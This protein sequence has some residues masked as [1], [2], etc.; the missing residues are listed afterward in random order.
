MS[1]IEDVARSW[2][3]A[4]PWQR[5]FKHTLDVAQDYAAATMVAVGAVALSVRLLTTLGSGDLGKF[6]VTKNFNEEF[7]MAFL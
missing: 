1:G 2:L 4:P 3:L 7:S 5:V 6:D